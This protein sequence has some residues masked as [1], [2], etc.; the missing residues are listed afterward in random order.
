VRYSI[1]LAVIVGCAWVTAAQA[2][3]VTGMRLWLDA[4]DNSTF[5]FSSG[6]VVSAWNDKSGNA[7]NFTQGTVANQPTR[8]SNVLNNQPVVRFDGVNDAL[9]NGGTLFTGGLHSV[10]IVF[11]ATKPGT[12]QGVLD[13]TPFGNPR[14]E[15]Y[16]DTSGIHMFRG[17]GGDVANG[18]Y[19]SGDYVIFSSIWNGSSSA[20]WIDGAGQVTGTLSTDASATTTN[21]LGSDAN[22]SEY[23]GDIAEVLVYNSALSTADRLA[24]EAY[25]HEKWVPEPASLSLVAVLGLTLVRSRRSR[26]HAAMP[27]RA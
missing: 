13:G 15:V 26:R 2:A 7:L 12:Y 3:P 20:S 23:L 9:T 22:S 6:N 27:R 5:T 25:L 17:A 4:A 14:H 11:K 24:N 10:F 18:N 1:L 16:I 21:I 19:T 8:V